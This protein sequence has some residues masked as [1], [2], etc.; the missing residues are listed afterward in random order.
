MLH[1]DGM[2]WSVVPV[3]HPGVSNSLNAL[4]VASPSDVWASG[5]YV[6]GNGNYATWAAHWDGVSWST[7]PT[8]TF[9]PYSQLNSIAVISPSDVWAVGEYGLGTN[10]W[11][12]LTE[13]WNG[14]SWSQ[15]VAPSVGSN[16][17]LNKV[18]TIPGGSVIAVGLDN[19]LPNG[20]LMLIW[21][22]SAWL[23]LTGIPRDVL[24]R[25]VHAV[26]PT[27]VWVVGQGLNPFGPFVAECAL[28]VAG[29]TPVGGAVEV[30]M[31][32]QSAS[33]KMGWLMGL[34]VVLAGAGLGIATY[35]IRRRRAQRPP[36]D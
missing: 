21:S 28:S 2:S 11:T 1:W 7:I 13:H 36:K 22:G 23:N 31:R 25:D 17:P 29:V 32:S 20:A 5:A 9:P 18:E 6:L 10:Q 24:L 8:P 34:S 30:T 12:P 14:S 16:S 3:P 19:G 4:A 26:S 33:Y 35:S 27:R 15:V